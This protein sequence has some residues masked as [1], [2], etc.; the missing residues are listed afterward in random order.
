M[1]YLIPTV[2][3]YAAAYTGDVRPSFASKLP[4]CELNSA[5]YGMDWNGG[6]PSPL[7]IQQAIQISISHKDINK[8]IRRT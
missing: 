3:T 7:E 2:I 5:V 1:Q 8:F 4:A 6:N